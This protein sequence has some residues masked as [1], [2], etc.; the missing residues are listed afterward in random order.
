[1]VA[2]LN[3]YGTVKYIWNDFSGKTTLSGKT[4]MHF[5]KIFTIGIPCKFNLSGTTKCLE[6]PHFLE[7]YSRVVV[8][9]SRITLFQICQVFGKVFSTPSITHD[10]VWK[11]SCVFGGCD[12]TAYQ[13]F[14]YKAALALMLIQ[15]ELSHILNDISNTLRAAFCRSSL[16]YGR[17]RC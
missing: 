13:L 11:V 17:P 7:I 12:R 9:D 16:G 2:Y 6:R 3:D 15:M 10:F 1:M 8:P 4:I 5:V 14:S